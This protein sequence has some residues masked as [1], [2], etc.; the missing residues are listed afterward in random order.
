MTPFSAPLGSSSSIVG[1]SS[2]IS[3]AGWEGLRWSALL[4]EDR[5]RASGVDPLAPKP[6]HH[7]A[8]ARNVIHIFCTGAVS[9]LDTWDYKPEL[10]KRNGEPMPG[11]D[12]IVTFQGEN[13]NIARSPWTFRPRGES[14]K[15]ISDLLPN[16]AELADELCFI[17]SMTSKTNTHGPGEMF[18]STGF[19]TEGFP[20]MGAWASYALGTQNRELPAFVAIPDPRG[21]PQQGPAN[22][23]SGFLPAVNQGTAFNADRPIPHLARPP[24]LSDRNDLAGRDFLRFLNDEHLK[25]NPADTELS[26]RIASYE[27]AA[28]DATERSRRERPHTRDPRDARAL[29]HE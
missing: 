18:M 26:A 20:S 4:R 6:T 21:V 25:K 14:G 19:T 27:L 9:H 7:P 10:I 22:W 16:L 8:K 11:V 13:G 12:K 24:K 29:R 1:A 17:Q 23:A 2:A 28:Q 15:M 3:A 5:V